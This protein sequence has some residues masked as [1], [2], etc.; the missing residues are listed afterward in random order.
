MTDEQFARLP[1]YAQ[2]EIERLR[3]NVE[4]CQEQLNQCSVSGN[5]DTAIRKFGHDDI[6]LPRGSRIVFGDIETVD[7]RIEVHWEREQLVVR[8]GAIAIE[9]L[10]RSSNLVFVRLGD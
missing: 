4:Y 3:A 6:Q 2:Q 5:T 9:V 10:P 8:G 1:K 7:R